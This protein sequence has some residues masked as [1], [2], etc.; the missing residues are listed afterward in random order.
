VKLLVSLGMAVVA[1][2]D[3][4]WWPAVLSV[5]GAVRRDGLR[6]RWRA[7]SVVAALWC[8]LAARW[9]SA[10]FRRWHGGG[11]RQPSSSSQWLLQGEGGGFA[12]E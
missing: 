8:G 10:R 4:R 9:R 6:H 12:L 11:L 3:W 2:R 1:V 5:S 7:G